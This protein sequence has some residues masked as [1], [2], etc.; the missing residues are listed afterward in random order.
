MT[1][2]SNG[3]ASLLGKLEADIRRHKFADEEALAT[4]LLNTYRDTVGPAR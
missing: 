1:D 3:S 4:S 2:V